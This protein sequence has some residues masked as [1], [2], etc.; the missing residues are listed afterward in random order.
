MFAPTW[1]T[2]EEEMGTQLCKRNEQTPAL[3]HLYRIPS[4]GAVFDRILCVPKQS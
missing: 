2:V 1:K 3:N 4:H